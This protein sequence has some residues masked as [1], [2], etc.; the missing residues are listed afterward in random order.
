MAHDEKDD[1]DPVTAEAE[2]VPPPPERVTGWR[3]AEAQLFGSVHMSPELYQAAVTWVRHVVDALRAEGDSWA[4]L[5]RAHARVGSLASAAVTS[6]LDPAMVGRAA[7][8]IRHREVEAVQAARGR[9]LL[10]DAGRAAGRQWVVLEER[11]ATSGDLFAPYRRLEAEVGTGRVLLVTAEPDE[12][13]S[14]CVHAVQE[15]RMNPASGYLHAGPDTVARS[16]HPGASER[17]EHV[18]DLRLPLQD[19]K[20]FL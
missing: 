8:A 3:Q 10:L 14:R 16:T 2:E 19:A 12:T 11:G 18:D 7:L 1:I 13:M 15:A 9:V 6:G 4:V 20:N 5:A 17:E